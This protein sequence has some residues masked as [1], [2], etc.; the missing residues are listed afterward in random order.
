VFLFREPFPVRTP[1]PLS[2]CRFTRRTPLGK[3]GTPESSCRGRWRWST[4]RGD[5]VRHRY[6]QHR[7]G[8]KWERSLAL[9]PGWKRREREKKLSP[10]EAGGAA[11]PATLPVA[12]D[13]VLPKWSHRLDARPLPLGRPHPPTV[14][15]RASAGRQPGKVLEPSWFPLLV[16]STSMHTLDTYSSTP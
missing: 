7:V 8:A 14:K 10:T 5:R 13:P 16:R 4:Q 11:L 9:E 6:V 15:H 3:P 1:R 12:G 2:L